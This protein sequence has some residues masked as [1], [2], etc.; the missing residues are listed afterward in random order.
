MNCF[1]HPTEVA[2]VFC[3]GCGKPL[4]LECGRQTFGNETHVCSEGCART[5]NLQPDSGEPRESIFD[6]VYAA[7]FLTVFMAVLGGGLSV[8]IIKQAVFGEEVDTRIDT[9]MRRTHFVGARYYCVRLF[10]AMGITDWRAQFGIG[11]AI[12]AGSAVLFLKKNGTKA[13]K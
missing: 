11:A 10:S 1:R 5:V 3:K 2:T 9:H 13:G 7:V 12:G 6:K 4:C 8:W